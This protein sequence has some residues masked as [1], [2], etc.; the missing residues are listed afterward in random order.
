MKSCDLLITAGWLLPIAPENIALRDHGVAVQDGR[1]LAVDDNTVLRNTYESDHELHLPQQI[2]L[3]GLVNAHGHAAMT[4]LRGSGED[5]PLQAWLQ[6][7]IWPL[8]ARLMSREFVQLGTEL[9]MAEMLK[10]GTT[11]DAD[12]YFLPEAVAASA[13]R[14]GM[15]AQVAFPI[16]EFANVWSENVDEALHKGL[17]IYDEYRH[18]DL[19]QVALGPHSAY[20][21]SSAN[22]QRIAMYA[23]ELDAQVQ[24]HLHENAEEVAQAEAEHGRTWIALLDEQGLLGPN[25]QA[26]HMTS[27]N[28]ADLEL[29][30]Q[31]G[32]KVVHCPTSNLKLASGLCRVAEFVAAGVSVGLGTDGAASN[33]SLDLFFE[34]RLAALMAKS[35]AG[36]AAIGGAPDTLRMATLDSA[37]VLG[38]DHLIGSLEPGKQADLISVDASRLGLLPVHDPFAAVIHGHGGASVAHVYINGKAKVSEGALC[39]FDEGELSRRVYSWHSQHFS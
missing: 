29:V 31:T 32:A 27:V 1:I 26:V 3:P 10:S 25:L 37:R 19:V 5:R 33:N 11:T 9:A 22:L 13:R 38:L 21:V 35:H 39:V 8:E 16:V 15:R 4:L 14:A 23:N 24:T 34:A 7:V 2:V 36:D 18:D 6:Q 28:Q 17:A 12:M 20:T 30:A